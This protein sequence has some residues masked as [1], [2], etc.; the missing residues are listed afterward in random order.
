M[1]TLSSD[2][3]LTA[4]NFGVHHK[5]LYQ[6]GLS[7]LPPDLLEK[8]VALHPQHKNPVEG[9]HY[10]G[11][12]SLVDWITRGYEGTKRILKMAG[13]AREMLSY[14]RYSRQLKK[15]FEENKAPYEIQRYV[16]NANGRDHLPSPK[17]L[18]RQEGEPVSIVNEVNQAYDYSGFTFD[19]FKEHLGFV[20]PQPLI[21]VVNYNDN[22]L[23]VGYGNAF[24]SPLQLGLQMMVYGT[25][26]GRIFNPFTNDL[27]VIAHEL[28]HAYTDNVF[29]GKFEY[30]GQPGALNEHISDVIAK[31][32]EAKYRGWDELVGNWKIG[33][34]LMVN[35]DFALR[36][37]SY[38]GEAYDDPGLGKDA[39]VGHMK[40][41]V[42]TEKDEGG[43][44]INS[45]IMNRVFALF[46]ER[47]KGPVYE[48]PLEIW[49]SAMQSVKSVPIFRDFGLALLKVA[50]D[51]DLMK[52]MAE[53]LLETG[54]LDYVVKE[55][56]VVRVSPMPN[57]GLQIS[58][59]PEQN[60]ELKTA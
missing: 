5:G 42:V 22:P 47:V 6:V 51:H 49:V 40:D 50:D 17:T 11:H 4:A 10:S 36:S 53:V 60:K 7:A 21:Q 25:G 8:Y 24:F 37:M 43:V 56:Q 12:G 20:L 15:H 3:R 35:P 44:H 48:L 54:V 59:N 39:Q 45:G 38:P 46:S 14:M 33:A 32:V 29:A 27:T 18:A 30:K 31:C 19:F 23:F 41:F 1:P 9:D 26:D 34:D 58:L 28:S 13:N 55:G 52:P 2:V 16:Y 57:E